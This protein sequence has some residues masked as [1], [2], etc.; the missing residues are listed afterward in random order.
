LRMAEDASDVGW[1]QAR[2]TRWRQGLSVPAKEDVRFRIGSA[3]TKF[4]ITHR[5]KPAS[6]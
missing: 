2:A 3:A 6:A 4:A 5:G 1:G